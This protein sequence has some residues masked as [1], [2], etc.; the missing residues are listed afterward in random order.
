MIL[1]VLMVA[2][3]ET[4]LRGPSQVGVNWK[5][6]QDEMKSL[7][8]MEFEWAPPELSLQEGISSGHV[9]DAGKMVSDMVASELLNL[10]RYE[11]RERSDL[12]RVLEEHELQLSDIMAKGDYRL[13]GEIAG[14]NGVV[15]GRVNLA[16]LYAMGGLV[17]AEVSFTC[18]CVSTRTGDLVWSIGGDM[19]VD[20]AKM[21]PPHW[22]RMLAKE[23][24]QELKGKLDH[25]PPGAQGAKSGG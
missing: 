18:R 13:I 21:S 14:V 23:L 8:V 25:P 22:L 7:G 3:C 20:L 16:N 12:K 2:G 17:K 24:V 4:V 10:N 15:I 11:I 19:A 5:F 9:S 6:P 1:A